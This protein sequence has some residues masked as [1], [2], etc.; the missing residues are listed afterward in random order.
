MKVIMISGKS[1]HGKDAFS[2]A[3][4][5]YGKE[6]GNKIIVI[7]FADLVKYYAKQYYNW[8]GEKDN[9]GRHLLQYIGTTLM[10]GYR[11]K[12]WAQIVAEF[13]AAASKDFDIALIPDWRF[14]NE[15]YTV[16]EY[17]PETYTIRVERHDEEG[18]LYKNP[19]MTEEQLNHIS[20][21]E[22]DHFPFDWKVINQDTLE[23]LE[24]SAQTL[25]NVIINGEDTND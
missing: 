11:S 3:F 17:N 15:F 18:N 24:G 21:T 23:L 2:N 25:F 7:H 14:A 16:S 4:E 19:N 12:Y 6:K 8:N 1:G 20:E 22:L 13:L 10:R 9:D 5:Q